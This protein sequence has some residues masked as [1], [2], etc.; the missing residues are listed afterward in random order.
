MTRIFYFWNFRHIKN[1]VF[2]GASLTQCKT[3]WWFGHGNSKFE[4]ISEFLVY[5]V[6]NNK[7]SLRFL[8]YKSMFLQ[9]KVFLCVFVAVYN[10]SFQYETPY[11]MYFYYSWPGTKKLMRL[12][13]TI[14]LK[15][16]VLS[17][18]NLKPILG[19]HFWKHWQML[20]WRRS[21]VTRIEILVEWEDWQLQQQVSD[22]LEWP[23]IWK[24]IKLPLVTKSWA[25]QRYF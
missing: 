19:L 21:C 1:V 17:V 14:C 15:L 4:N 24:I 22:L 25:I 6:S 2:L 5:N 11:R 3:I 12:A 10:I 16:R 7:K 18:I 13:K 23:S 20:K 9:K 8:E